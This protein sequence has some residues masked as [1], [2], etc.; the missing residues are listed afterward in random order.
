MLARTQR[1]QA[2]RRRTCCSDGFLRP[3]RRCLCSPCTGHFPKH[4]L[5]QIWSGLAAGHRASVA[6]PEARRVQRRQARGLHC[7]DIKPIFRR[8]AASITAK[9]TVHGTPHA[10]GQ[11]PGLC[12][13]E[14]DR[15]TVARAG[16]AAPQARQG[17]LPVPHAH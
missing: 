9:H 6:P 10:R 3:L 5:L 16:L 8:L 2:L 17:R 1:H 12:A 15:P 13:C 4:V 11:P 7:V 14:C